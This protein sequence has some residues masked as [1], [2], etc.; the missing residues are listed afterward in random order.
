MLHR[1]SH[2]GSEKSCSDIAEVT[3]RNADD[4]ILTSR[5]C[6]SHALKLGIGVEIIESLGQEARHIDGVG[7][8]QLHVIVELLIHE[9]VL[10]QRLTVIEDTVDLQ[11]G[12]VAPQSSELALLDFANFSLGIENI[13]VDAVDAE[14]AVCHSRSCVA[15]GCHEHVDLMMDACS[16]FVFLDEI[17]Q[18]TGHEAGTHIFESQSRAVEELKAV[19]VVFDLVDR[20]VKG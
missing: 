10:H 16:L 1:Q 4:H 5:S 2:A 3:T 11:C 15:R 8:S 20:S 9:R 14:E 6:K 19:D 13:D 12:D 7:R 17:L 18:Q